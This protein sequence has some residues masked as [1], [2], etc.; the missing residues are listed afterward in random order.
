MVGETQVTNDFPSTPP[1]PATMLPSGWRGSPGFKLV[2]ILGLSLLMLIPMTMVSFRIEE[3]QERQR[4]VLDD[5]NKSWGPSQVVRGPTLVIPYEMPAASGGNGMDRNYIRVMPESLQ[6][7]ASLSPE[8][9]KRGLFHAIVYTADIGLKGSFRIPVEALPAGQT[10]KILWSESFIQL[11]ATDWGDARSLSATAGEDSMLAFRGA[12]D[13]DALRCKGVE[14]VSAQV[15]LHQA[16]GGETNVPFEIHTDLRGTG[17]FGIVALGRSLEATMKAP[18]STPSFGG[19]LLPNTSDINDAGFEAQ[20]RRSANVSNTPWAWSAHSADCGNAGT[21]RQLDVELLEPV[22]TYRMVDRASK[23]GA[24]F[25]ALSFLTYFLFEMIGQVRIHIVQYALLGL[26]ISLFALLLVS[27][28][29]P[30][31]FGLGYAIST[32]AILAQ[33]SVYTAS[34]TRKAKQAGVFALMLSCLFGFLYVVLSLESYALLTGTVALFAVLSIVMAVTRHID[35]S[36]APALAA[37][38]LE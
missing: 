13:R 37:K 1:G 14:L 10:T 32:L 5:F 23:Y 19:A 4:S 7:V 38:A 9:R 18:W 28:S 15:P 25:I 27:F 6:A 16:A 11:G 35:W 26:S 21:D 17:N 31:G 8:T 29:E 34:I 3:R 20:W 24:L 36:K 33:A 12:T 22:P 2:L 30:L